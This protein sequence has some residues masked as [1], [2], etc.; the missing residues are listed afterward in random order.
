[1]EGRYLTLF[2]DPQKLAQD[3]Y[4]RHESVGSKNSESP[5]Y[6][7]PLESIQRMSSERSKGEQELSS[8]KK[9]LN[10]GPERN[11]F[12]QTPTQAAIQRSY[13]RCVGS[14][15]LGFSIF[16]VASLAS[17]I[18]I[19]SVAFGGLIGAAYYDS[20]NWKWSS[21]LSNSDSVIDLDNAKVR[22]LWRNNAMTLPFSQF[23][24]QIQGKKV[25]SEGKLEPL[26]MRH[27][28]RYDL[29]RKMAPVNPEL[30]PAF[31]LISG[32]IKQALDHV[33]LAHTANVNQVREGF[34]DAEKV[35]AVAEGSCLEKVRP[36]IVQHDHFLQEAEAQRKRAIESLDTQFSVMV[37]HKSSTNK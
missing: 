8:V 11:F 27:I 30:K 25:Y 5:E 10:R 6:F 32:R 12:R 26:S 9:L 3:L 22:A 24:N 23:L 28:T 18:A 35:P 31:Y 19:R 4:Q 13:M 34:I 7:E 29:F 37:K 17:D 14:F 1:M 15:V 2:R 16:A 36:Q 21:E 33:A 20:K